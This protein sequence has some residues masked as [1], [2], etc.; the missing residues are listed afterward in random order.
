MFQNLEGLHAGAEAV[1]GAKGEDDAA[2]RVAEKA[3]LNE[4]INQLKEL[5]ESTRTARREALEQAEATKQK[6]DAAKRQID[7]L[8]TSV[9]ALESDKAEVWHIFIH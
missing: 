7:I 6:A 4:E 2:R 9:S 8:Q 1:N 3:R 5:L